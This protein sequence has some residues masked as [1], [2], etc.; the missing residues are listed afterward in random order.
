[1][2]IIN[3]LRIKKLDSFETLRCAVRGCKLAESD[4]EEQTKLKGRKM[5]ISPSETN[6]D[7]YIYRIY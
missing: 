1:M 7:N 4:V 5:K 6:K 2:K 3:L